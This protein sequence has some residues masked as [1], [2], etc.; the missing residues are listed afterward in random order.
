ML[1][2]RRS[3][4][5]AVGSTSTADA[6]SLKRL[7]PFN[8]REVK[9]PSAQ[10]GIGPPKNASTFSTKAMHQGE[11]CGT[12]LRYQRGLQE[13][14]ICRSLRYLIIIFLGCLKQNFGT[15]ILVVPKW[16]RHQTIVIV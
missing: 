7:V 5:S 12:P 10:T 8:K 3:S 11:H 4:T 16:A 14:K 1:H 13:L 6:V 9:P 2:S 15:A